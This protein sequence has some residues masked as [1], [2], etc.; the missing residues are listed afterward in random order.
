M[1]QSKG[2]CPQ[3]MNFILQN[4]E[5]T[6]VW[7][8]QSQVVYFSGAMLVSGSVDSTKKID[9]HIIPRKFPQKKNTSASITSLLYFPEQAVS[10]IKPSSP[11]CSTA[12][13]VKHMP[14]CMSCL[15][16]YNLTLVESLQSITCPIILWLY[17]VN[18]KKI[19]LHRKQKPSRK[20]ASDQPK[21]QDKK[22][23]FEQCGPHEQNNSNDKVKHLWLVNQPPPNV[24]PPEIR[25]Y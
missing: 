3:D 2:P 7:V 10:S 9:Q 6:C 19:S 24:P 23:N 1:F 12:E 14:Q 20:A 8:A 11:S 5:T 4:D 13:K 25:P 16:C 22:K 15:S 18:Y 17:H 21:V